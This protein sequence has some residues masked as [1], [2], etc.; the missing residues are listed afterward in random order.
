M[1]LKQNYNYQS[2]YSQQIYLNSASASIQLN[3]S[4][5][6]NCTF[7]FSDLIKFDKNAIEMRLELVN[8]QIPVSWYLINSTNN[9]FIITVSELI[10]FH[11]LSIS[12]R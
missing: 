9:T 1:A 7:F 4:K 5:K 12:F 2:I 11:N 6:S 8:A 3:G 10:N